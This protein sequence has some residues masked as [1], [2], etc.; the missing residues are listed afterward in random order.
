MSTIPVAHRVGRV[1][2]ARCQA[3]PSTPSPPT[4]S[5]RV[6]ASI[7]G[8]PTSTTARITVRHPSPSIRAT[9]ATVSP[10]APTRRA[11]QALARC[12]NTARDAAS[13]DDSVHVTVGQPGLRQRQTR[14]THTSTAERPDTGTSRSRCSRRACAAARRPH[15]PQCTTVAVVSTRTSS[16]PPYS[17]AVRTLNPGKSKTA[18][19]VRLVASSTTGA[20]RDPLLGRFGS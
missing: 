20:S 13:G 7:N 14:L 9:A 4:P 18:S 6:A 2:L 1:R 11:T 12:V 3:C 15:R 17:P 5:M 8:S 10:L 16:S 19:I